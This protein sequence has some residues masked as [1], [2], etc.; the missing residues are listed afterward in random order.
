MIQ[1]R[2]P[3]RYSLLGRHTPSLTDFRLAPPALAVPRV[4]PHV[5][6]AGQKLAN[7]HTVHSHTRVWTSRVRYLTML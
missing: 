7:T 3:L 4:A 1:T 6:P 2:T 5:A